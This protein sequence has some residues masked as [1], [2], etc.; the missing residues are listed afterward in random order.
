MEA[1]GNKSVTFPSRCDGWTLSDI[2]RIGEIR[3]PRA[4]YCDG[5]ILILDD[6]R[7]L[8]VWFDFRQSESGLWPARN[9]VV[10]A[11]ASGL[12]GR[13]FF[14]AFE[15][16]PDLRQKLSDNGWYPLSIVVPSPFLELALFYAE[17]KSKE[18]DEYV[19]EQVTAETLRHELAKWLKSTALKPRRQLLNEV[20]DLYELKRYAGCETLAIAQFNG[21][22]ADKLGVEHASDRQ[23]ATGVDG[24]SS[25]E[26]GSTLALAKPH[27]LSFART[28]FE[29]KGGQVGARMP[30][31]RKAVMH[32]NKIDFTSRDALQSALLLLTLCEA[33]GT[34]EWPGIPSVGSL[35]GLVFPWNLSLH[36]DG[37]SKR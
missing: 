13:Q 12:F 5:F 6:G 3:I 33:I 14:A 27:F 15:A 35:C 32:G 17:G 22:V 24:L 26:S 9:S 36:D 8:H 18:G 16:A 10:S 30:H 11:R 21:L 20:I 28:V 4:R 34:S 23:I 1:N 19:A 31:S 29:G 7:K 25:A 37:A 2:P